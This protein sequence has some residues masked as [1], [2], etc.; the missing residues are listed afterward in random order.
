MDTPRISWPALPIERWEP[1]RATLHM[2][3]Q[4]VGKIRLALSPHLNHWW[5]VPLYVSARGLST[6]A[7]AF[8]NGL[9]ELEFDFLDHNL[10]IRDSSRAAKYIPLYERSVADFHRELIGVL[11]AMSIDVRI[12]HTPV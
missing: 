2:W 6:S 5:E 12:W 4:I 9:L 7:I 11:R 10:A 3:T 1:T 8:R